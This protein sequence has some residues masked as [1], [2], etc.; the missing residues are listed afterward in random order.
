MQGVWDRLAA[1]WNAPWKEHY[2]VVAIVVSLGWNLVNTFLASKQWRRNQYF[3]EF[4]SLKTPV[5]AALGKL[6]E[7]RQKIQSAGTFGGDADAFNSHFQT[8]NKE[9]TER[10]ISLII[11]LQA[12]DSSP[13]WPK[14]DLATRY[15]P[16][17]DDVILLAEGIYTQ[18]TVDTKKRQSAIVASM[19]SDLI[20]QVA[21]EIESSLTDKIK[22]RSFWKKLNPRN[23]FRQPV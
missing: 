3:N 21:K 4:R 11:S 20:D 18:H 14:S 19:I 7:T 16:K 12:C 9:L 8:I 10:W 1:L 5:D 15:E 23:W 22:G 2:A 13:H 17:W 6:R